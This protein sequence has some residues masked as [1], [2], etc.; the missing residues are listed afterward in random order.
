MDSYIKLK[1][2]PL[3]SCVSCILCI[4]LYPSVSPIAEISLERYDI[5]GVPSWSTRLELALHCL[6]VGPV[7][8]LSVE[9]CI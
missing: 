3:Y 8:C 1:M 5:F 4:P 2:H 7:M 9:S 6:N